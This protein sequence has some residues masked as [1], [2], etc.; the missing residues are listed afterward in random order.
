MQALPPLPYSL[1]NICFP[2][3]DPTQLLL[4]QDFD[5]SPAEGFRVQHLLDLAI[6]SFTKQVPHQILSYQLGPFPAGL[7]DHFR[8]VNAVDESVHPHRHQF[9][10]DKHP[11]LLGLLQIHPGIN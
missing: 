6:G 11:Q 10:L 8:G 3:G 2:I 1:F 5:C 7:I 4:L 9:T